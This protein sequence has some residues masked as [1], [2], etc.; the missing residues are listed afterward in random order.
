MSVASE[1]RA[2]I[3]ADRLWRSEEIRLLHNQASGLA[4]AKKGVFRRSLV[5][6]VYA[7]LEGFCAR[8]LEIYVAK[9]NGLS[10]KV[11]D[12]DWGLA[13]AA[14]AQTFDKL[15]NK[16]LK[17]SIFKNDL[18]EDAKLHRFARDRDFLESITCFE[19]EQVLVDSDLVVSTDSNLK[20]VVLRKMLFRLGLDHAM[21]DPW[22]GQ[23]HQLLG[24]RNNLSLIHI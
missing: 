6:M 4:E 12:V 23:L 8:A 20:P 7:H 24:K 15:H 2:E 10:L 3:E 14:L 5:V 19:Q 1:A 21:A 16:D 17:C 13:T 18:P 11:S 9:I 22:S